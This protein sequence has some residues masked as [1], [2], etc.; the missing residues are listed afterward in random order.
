MTIVP[1]NDLK[2]QLKGIIAEKPNTIT[3]AVATEAL[4]YHCPKAFFTDLLNHGCVSG[5]VGTLIYYVDTH[6]FFD[7][8]Y[9]EIETLR[10][11]YEDNIGEVLAIKGD[12]KNFMAWF[13]FEEVAFRIA[14][15]KGI[16]F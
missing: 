6:S 1:A 16:E 9:G 13:A 12:L 8:H 11:D 10:E 7:K 4:N 15:D 2:S 3:A 5:M 14:S